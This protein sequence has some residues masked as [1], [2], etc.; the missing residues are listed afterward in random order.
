MFK[1]FEHV[2]PLIGIHSV[3]SLR[4]VRMFS[5]HTALKSSFESSFFEEFEA[6]FKPGHVRL[7]S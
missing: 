5:V 4:F 7:E 2:C 6:I 3:R 1:M